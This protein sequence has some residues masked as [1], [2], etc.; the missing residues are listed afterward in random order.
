MG[1]V[2]VITSFIGHH[3][4]H[5]CFCYDNY[6]CYRWLRY[7]EVGGSN[8]GDAKDGDNNATFLPCGNGGRFDGGG[9]SAGGGSSDGGGGDGVGSGAYGK[10]RTRR[11]DW[12]SEKRMDVVKLKRN[13]LLG[14]AI[15]N[16]SVC[17]HDIF[18]PSWITRPFWTRAYWI[19]LEL[20]TL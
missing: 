11:K 12:P 4:F 16:T 14:V 19:R 15:M 3:Y 2:D 6:C 17:F 8:N 18:L 10:D 20:K 13:M 7:G 1:H 9:V 5:Y